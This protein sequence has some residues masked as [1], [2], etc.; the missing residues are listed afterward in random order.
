MMEPVVS[1]RDDPNYSQV[2]GYVA[3]A[4]AL[5]F[6]V[7]CTAKEL[8]RS[9]ALEEAIALWLEKLEQSK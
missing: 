7:A 2:S 8:P 3:K 4:L 1:K 9:E 5:R 6:K